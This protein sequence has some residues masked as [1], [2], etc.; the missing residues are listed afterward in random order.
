MCALNTEVPIMENEEA[1]WNEKDANKID[2]VFKLD[3]YFP[4][5]VKKPI[6]WEDIINEDSDAVPEPNEMGR[7][8]IGYYS[9]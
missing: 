6:D 3:E 7:V 9:K 5:R 4:D 2:P 1:D 8:T